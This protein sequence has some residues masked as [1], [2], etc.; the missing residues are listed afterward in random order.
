MTFHCGGASCL[1][2]NGLY[3]GLES[4]DQHGCRYS[5][6][7]KHDEEED[8]DSAS[9]TESMNL[10]SALDHYDSEVDSDYVS[11]YVRK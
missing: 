11:D 9:E 4:P 6:K 10:A 5:E 1:A 8:E 7:R 3:S 2:I